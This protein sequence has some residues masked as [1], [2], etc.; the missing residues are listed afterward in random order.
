D[1]TLGWLFKGFNKLFDW[2]TAG[3][4]RLVGGAL[5]V[6]LLALLLY[7]GLLA[8]TYYGFTHAPTGFIPQQ[9]KGYLLVNVQLPGSASVQRTPQ[10]MKKVDEIVK[11]P[12]GV[13]HRLGVNGQSLLIN[14]NGSNFGSMYVI[15]DEF[16][17][18]HGAD[19]YSDAIAAKIRKRCA[20][21]IE[22]AVVAVF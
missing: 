9:D 20:E 17:N 6:T 8:L 18:R 10:V 2:G 19:L 1:L 7:G 21:E 16:H 5:R 15:L 11:S 14:A 4:A 12:P 22:G 3:Y 13:A